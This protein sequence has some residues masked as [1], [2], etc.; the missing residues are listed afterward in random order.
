VLIGRRISSVSGSA[1]GDDLKR[2]FGARET[3]LGNLK[4]SFSAVSFDSPII[5]SDNSDDGGMVN[6]SYQL[7]YWLRRISPFQPPVLP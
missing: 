7:F 6:V 1:E 3:R 2:R 5:R 4:A